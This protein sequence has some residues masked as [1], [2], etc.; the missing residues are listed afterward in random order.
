MFSLSSIIAA[1]AIGAEVGLRC[2]PTKTDWTPLRLLRDVCAVIHELIPN[3]IVP[4][5]DKN[6]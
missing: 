6:Q 5:H 1:L 4:R 3:N 2:L